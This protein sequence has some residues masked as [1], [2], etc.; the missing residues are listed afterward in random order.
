V[1]D[2]DD[3]HGAAQ[4]SRFAEGLEPY[5]ESPTPI[6][7]AMSRAPLAIRQMNP[8]DLLVLQRQPSQALQ[9]G[10]EIRATVGH[11]RDMIERGEA[12]T[13]W[14]GLTPICCMGILESFPGVQGIAW[15]VLALGI[16]WDHLAITRH[17]KRQI[18]RS[19]LIRIEALARTSVPAECSWARAVGLQPEALIRKF[20]AASEDHMLYSRIR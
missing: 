9:L 16:G 6:G 17:A 3:Q 11:A 7:V 14:R 20:G 4:V 18:A 13:A 12:W 19:P 15:A 1:R 2:A 10:M 8:E 5:R